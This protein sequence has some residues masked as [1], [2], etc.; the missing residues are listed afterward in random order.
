MIIMSYI[1]RNIFTE[2][3]EKAFHVNYEIWYSRT[4][5]IRIVKQQL[6]YEQEKEN[7]VMFINEAWYTNTSK[8][9]DE[10][11]AQERS[12]VEV[13]WLSLLIIVGK[14]QCLFSLSWKT[15]SQNFCN[16]FIV[17]LNDTSPPCQF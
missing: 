11:L 2:D 15:L 1:K 7:F 16:N 8:T 4:K 14:R 9:L 13:K 17:K 6:K 10:F 5:K 3:F 12:V